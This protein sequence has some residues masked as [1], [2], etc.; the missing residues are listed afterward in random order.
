MKRTILFTVILAACSKTQP[1]PEQKDP[2]KDPKPATP[3][4]APAAKDPLAVGA[5]APDF[6][7]VAHDGKRYK[8]SALAGHPVVLYFY[9]K[10]DTPG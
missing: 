6:D 7:A 4:A 8:L 10:A 9:P 5:V 1:A 2:P 3:A